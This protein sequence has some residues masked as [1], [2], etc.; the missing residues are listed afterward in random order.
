MNPSRLAVIRVLGAAAILGAATAHA[1]NRIGGIR[2]EPAKATAGAVV[3]I[4]VSS[5]VSDVGHC[6]FAVEFGDGGVQNIR[7]SNKDGIFP[8]TLKHVYAKP[9]TYTVRAV[10]DRMA[11]LPAC[12]GSVT[13]KVNVVAAPPPRPARR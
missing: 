7:V 10:G 3:T 1:S 4:I 2:V 6:G 9:G 13:A 8:K 11:P 12:L 5:D